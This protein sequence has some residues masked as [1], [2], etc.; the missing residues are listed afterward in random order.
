[1]IFVLRNRL[2]LR[3]CVDSSRTIREIPPRPP[4]DQTIEEKPSPAQLST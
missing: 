1:M 4:S 2:I 3:S